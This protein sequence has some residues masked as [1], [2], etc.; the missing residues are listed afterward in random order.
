MY[1]C[2]RLENKDQIHNFR[3][4]IREVAQCLQAIATWTR[5]LPSDMV[6]IVKAVFI[7]AEGTTFKD[8]KP[9]TRLA[10]FDLI[11][12]MFRTHSKNLTRNTNA[13][14]L[15]AGL[16]S[17]AELEKNPSCLIVVFQ[18]YEHISREWELQDLDLK[19]IW[20]SFIRYF[21][22]TVGSAAQDRAVPSRE[23]LKVSLLQCI[24]SNEFYAGDAFT[25]CLEM[26]DVN[27]DISANLKV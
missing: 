8:Q 3:A 22:I 19:S 7:L 21:P 24:I 14:Y 13:H 20:E 1:L 26:L 27:S 10:L 11:D 4:G 18:L 25:R 2:A 17:M 9:T 12:Y 15:V 5:L 23:D 16:V 6:E